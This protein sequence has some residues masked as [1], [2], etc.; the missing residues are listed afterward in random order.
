MKFRVLLFLVPGFI[1]IGTIGYRLIEGWPWLDSLYMTTITLFT[2]GFRE[3][4]PLS[5]ASRVFTI[6][7]IVFGIG[8]VTYSL[9]RAAQ[10]A[11]EGKLRSVFFR[12]RSFAYMKKTK[13]HHI[14]CG[15][16][17]MGHFV[18]QELTRMKVPLI[19]VEQKEELRSELEAK[20]IP[21]IIGDATEE[22]T[23][24]AAGIDR[25]K[26]LSSLLPSDAQNLYVTLT[27]RSLNPQLYILARALDEKAE[28]KL[29]RAGA[30]KVIAPLRIEGF[31]IVNALLRPHVVEFMELV[32]HDT[33]LAL[34]LEEIYVGKDSSLV[35][36]TLRGSNLRAAFGIII[37]GIKKEK[38]EMLFNPDP[39]VSIKE[40]DLLIALGKPEDLERFSAAATGKQR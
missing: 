15:F 1:L 16:G 11:L 3:V 39:D 35:G 19:V 6:F 21:Y 32:T 37:V 24:L 17:R 38:R 7:L 33:S 10:L 34:G 25:A 23:L 13:N 28:R 30:T 27:A 8:I 12:R 5:P 22:D 14:I 4:H 29:L 2:V 18:V 20:R 9:W 36:K 40:G 31:K 26:S